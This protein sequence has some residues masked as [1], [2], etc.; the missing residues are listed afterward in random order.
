MV[1]Y[2]Y[3]LVICAIIAMSKPVN[4]DT[5]LGMVDNVIVLIIF[6]PYNPTSGT[7]VKPPTCLTVGRVDR[8]M[9]IM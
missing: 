8:G 2:L 4:G 3:D 7:L 5:L 6:Q 1:I 9:Q